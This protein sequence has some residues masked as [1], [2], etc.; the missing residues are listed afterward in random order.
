MP[1]LNKAARSD[2]RKFVPEWYNSY[3]S[4]DLNCTVSPKAFSGG[5]GRLAHGRPPFALADALRP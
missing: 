5:C 3:Q 2:A 4:F 1:A